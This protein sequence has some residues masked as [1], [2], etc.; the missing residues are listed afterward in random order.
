MRDWMGDVAPEPATVGVLGGFGPEAT[1]DFLGK[2][3]RC[4]P[5]SRDQDHLHL[6]VDNNPRVPN[7]NEAIAGSGPSPEPMLVAMAQRLEAAGA[8]FLVMPC[9]AAHAYA[10]CI[11]E[12]VS[13]PFV[14]IVEETRNHVME[15]FP[16][17]GRV[18]VLASSGCLDADLYQ[19]AFRE[20][21]VPVVVP[22][23]HDRAAFM[24]LLYRIKSGDKSDRVGQG[25]RAVASRL[26]EQGAEVLVAGCTEVPLVLDS[27]D[28]QVPLV[29]ST[30]VLAQKTVAL[31]R[32]WGLR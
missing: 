20:V 25:M 10:E 2:V 32:D 28:L 11:T 9:N 18:G 17:V 19:V 30:D 21:S 23:G 29:N 12:S 22:V 8:D 31:A 3:L 7:R 15:L 13:I 27:T 5:A 14:S 1:L 26:V 16:W 24:D 6:I 4:T